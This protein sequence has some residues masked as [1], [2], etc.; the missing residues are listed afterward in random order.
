MLLILYF[1]LRKV[2]ILHSKDNK[3][4]VETLFSLICEYIIEY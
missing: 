1:L 3:V 2:V 4:V